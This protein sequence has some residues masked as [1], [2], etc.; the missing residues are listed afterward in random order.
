MTNLKRNSGLARTVGLVLAVLAINCAIV[1]HNLGQTPTPQQAKPT[2]T[3]SPTPATKTDTT[4][5]KPIPLTPEQLQTLSDKQR[6]LVQ[7]QTEK[8]AITEK[9]AKLEAEWQLLVQKIRS[10]ALAAVDA[11]PRQYDEAITAL[12]SKGQSIGFVPKKP[13]ASETPNVIKVEPAKKN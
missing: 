7:A 5:A 10:A 3:P 13:P 8:V 6:E 1:A 12:D 11:D 9:V 2:A 4:Q